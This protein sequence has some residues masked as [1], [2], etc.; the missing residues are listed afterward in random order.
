MKPRHAYLLLVLFAS[1]WLPAAP[2]TALR[3]EIRV[4]VLID[5]PRYR[6]LGFLENLR[7]EVENVCGDLYQVQF[8][9]EWQLHGHWNTE[10]A[11]AAVDQLTRAPRDSVDLALVIGPAVASAAMQNPRLSLPT[12]VAF[13]TDVPED[14]MPSSNLRINSVMLQ[15]LFM[16]DLLTFQRVVP[17]KDVLV[18]T[19]A[20]LLASVDQYAVAQR[21]LT[22]GISLRFVSIPEAEPH[23][24]KYLDDRT[25]AVY[26]MPLLQ[27]RPQAFANL[28]NELKR[29]R[30]P[31]F[32]ML[33]QPE[34]TV[35]VLAGLNR[36]AVIA[37]VARACALDALDLLQGET[38]STPLLPQSGARLTLNVSTARA[39]NLQPGWSLLAEAQIVDPLGLPRG[40]P[41]SLALA[42]QT[43]LNIN[44]DL[45]VKDRV[46]AAGLEET[47][48]TRALRKP[49]IEAGLSAVQVDEGHAIPMLG[50]YEKYAAGSVTLNQL[51]YSEDANAGVFAQDALQRARVADRDALRADILRQTA[52]VLLNLMKAEAGL[53]V[54]RD[55]VN[56]TST[57]LELARARQT[58]G[59]ARPAEVFRWEAELAGAKASLMDAF[60]ARRRAERALSQLL[61]QPLHLR[62]QVEPVDLDRALEV[63]GGGDQA[64]LLGTPSGYHQLLQDLAEEALTHAPELRAMDAVIAA[65]DRERLAARRRQYMPTLGLQ[66][67]ANHILIKDES[68]ELDLGDLGLMLPE[69]EDSSWNVGI[70]ATLPLTTGGARKARLSQARWELERLKLDR[71]KTVDRLNQRLLSALDEAAASWPQMALRRTAA[72]AAAR[73]CDEVSAA[74]ARGAAS[75]LDLLDAQHAAF[76]ADLAAQTAVYDFI[77][78]W[79]EVRR[80]MAA[81]PSQA[82]LTR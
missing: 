40:E 52:S 17:L 76:T 23:L 62:W 54:H 53:Q 41:M 47:R 74:Y 31:S 60:S 48:K 6:D 35:G 71:V 58:V 25:Q 56:L 81:L 39:I 65:Q 27:V 14:W 77:D 24:E 80:A 78:D 18:L 7:R 50:Q 34:V 64:R 68:T 63:L 61:H 28:V 8:P 11:R 15:T 5:G 26:V 45:A 10:G 57:H 30:I 37:S 21:M 73:T 4:A 42:L 12:V 1:L 46:V 69:I 20:T 72:Q 36:D 19:D 79:A 13:A 29:R 2:A 49:Q 66:A 67:S 70:K 59:S 33:G 44:L 82:R 16:E 43:A 38:E 3:P 22:D 32:S 51:L 55:N 9:S 75:I